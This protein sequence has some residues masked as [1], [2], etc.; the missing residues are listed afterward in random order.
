M[1]IL[2]LL[3]SVLLVGTV[4]AQSPDALGLKAD[5]LYKKRAYS[6]AQVIYQQIYQLWSKQDSIEQAIDAGIQ[7]AEC[8]RKTR[9]REQALS[10]L[11][12]LLDRYQ[13]RLDK[14]SLS[15]AAIYHKKGANYYNLF[16]YLKA[17][18]FFQKALDIR[19]AQLDPNDRDIINGFHVIGAC[20]QYRGDYENAARFLEQAVARQSDPPVDKRLL[21]QSYTELARSYS[22]NGDYGKALE[23]FQAIL[24]FRKQYYADEPWLIASA[25]NDLVAHY[26]RMRDAESALDHAETALTIYQN[27]EDPYPEDFIKMANL[28][29][30]KAVTYDFAGDTLSAIESYQQSIKLHQQYNKPG[31]TYEGTAY[32]NLGS[33]LIPIDPKQAKINLEKGKE[34][35]AGQDEFAKLADVHL[36]LGDLEL[37]KNHFDQALDYYNRSLQYYAPDYQVIPNDRFQITELAIGDKLGFLEAL[38]AKAN[39]Y[40][41]KSRI[42]GDRKTLSDAFYAYQDVDLMVSTIR[43]DYQFDLSKQHLS[44]KLIPVYENAI[45]ASLAFTDAFD[46]GD[47]GLSTA[48]AY[49]EQSKSLTLLEAVRN[50]KAK[51]FSGIP[52]DLLEQS[53]QLKLELL[54]L[55][56]QIT[57]EQQYEDADL[58]YLSQLQ[59][60]RLKIGR[61]LQALNERFEKEFPTYFQLKINQNRAS[62]QTIQNYHLPEGKAIIEY[63]DGDDYLITFLIKKD[64]IQVFK[65]QKTAADKRA[66]NTLL[67]SLTAYHLS[68]NPSDELY[69]EMVSKM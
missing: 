1:K 68:P 63:F 43:Q 19:S 4:F 36:N 14:N 12:S 53:R 22:K 60:H 52:E 23:F 64:G 33:L 56:G 49:L 66:L 45:L 58:K 25:H 55:E 46:D 18:E 5:S 59:E 39:A 20:H 27:L 31:S 65:H 10:R 37:S 16:E 38:S 34:I 62:I 57:E 9:K 24:A 7:V 50:S 48:Y 30:N 44:E 8:D 26:N 54:D 6:K 47:L 69:Q 67:T 17:I 29:L 41:F 42:D 2:L 51:R 3:P 21:F 11:D 61:D 15:L 13:A 40:W 32:Y 28:Y 35:L